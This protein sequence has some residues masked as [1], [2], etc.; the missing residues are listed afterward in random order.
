M[1]QGNKILAQQAS[2]LEAS[3]HF[4]LMQDPIVSNSRYFAETEYLPEYSYTVEQGAT[5]N[6]YENSDPG[7]H[8]F[9]RVSYEKFWQS[10]GKVIF[11]PRYEYRKT[12]SFTQGEKND[13]TMDGGGLE[14]R[15]NT[16]FSK[17]VRWTFFADTEF[18]RLDSRYGRSNNSLRE[19]ITFD[20]TTTIIPKYTMVVSMR[21]SYRKNFTTHQETNEKRLNASISRSFGKNLSLELKG[22]NLLDWNCD[23]KIGRTAQYEYR[24]D[25]NQTGR[26]ITLQLFCKF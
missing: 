14:L 20:A 19:L 1:I 4:T 7:Y 11:V 22:E 23:K 21:Y 13:L 5:L 18:S 10:F 9:F 26:Y 24:R 16:N 17:K 15:I 8:L 2:A 6:T 25:Q 3:I 12:P